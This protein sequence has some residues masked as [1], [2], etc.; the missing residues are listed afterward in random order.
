MSALV[1]VGVVLAF[2]LACTVTVARMFSGPGPY[3]PEA[4]EA[5]DIVASAFD[6]VG[7]TLGFRRTVP[8]VPGDHPKDCADDCCYEVRMQELHDAYDWAAAERDMVEPWK[9]QAR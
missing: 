6:A 3:P 8:F 5:P 2:W 1:F 7:D 9:G 4:A